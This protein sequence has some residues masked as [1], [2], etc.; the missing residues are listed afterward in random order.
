MVSV[1]ESGSEGTSQVSRYMQLGEKQYFVRMHFSSFRYSRRGKGRG[2]GE[3][4]GE[5]MV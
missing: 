2:R 1:I 4:D 5:R 3:G